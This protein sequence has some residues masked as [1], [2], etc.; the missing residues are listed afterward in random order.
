LRSAEE[1]MQVIKSGRTTGVTCGIV[2]ST[3]TKDV[4]INFATGNSGCFGRF[5]GAICIRSISDKPF[6][7]KGDSGSIVVDLESGFPVA[8]LM[9]ATEDSYWAC[10][11]NQVC[12]DLH[13]CPAK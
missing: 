7:D 8:M 5:Q 13:V 10:D 4:T 12:S 2:C 11:L 3:K 9:G 6:S 1:G